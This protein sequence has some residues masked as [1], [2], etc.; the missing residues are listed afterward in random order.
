MLFLRKLC[1]SAV[2]LC[3]FFLPLN[4][5]GLVRYGDFLHVGSL[6]FRYVPDSMQTGRLSEQT[7]GLFSIRVQDFMTH[8][9]MERLTFTADL[10]SVWSSSVNIV[11]LDSSVLHNDVYYQFSP[12]FSF[13]IGFTNVWMND[14]HCSVES[15]YK[16]GSQVGFL[17]RWRW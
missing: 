3:F 14:H 6:V 12:N 8:V 2:G 17:A 5:M 9:G 13:G 10:I 11:S 16:S 1:L 15:S 4:S 7:D